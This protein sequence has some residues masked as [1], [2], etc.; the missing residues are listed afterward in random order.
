MPIYDAIVIGGGPAGC[1]TTITLQQQG[2]KVALL[3]AKKYPHHKVCGEFL[4]PECTYLL[5]QLGVTETLCAANPKVIDTVC[6]TAADDT[7]WEA[8]L[9]GQALGI[10]RYMLDAIM[11]AHAAQSGAELH[12]STT[13]TAIAGNIRDGFEVR[14]RNSK[15]EHSFSG[16]LVI[17]AH[18]KRSNLDRALRRRFLQK[19]QPYIGL[20]AHF[21]GPPLP[22]RI[23][24]HTFRG[25]YCG[26]S[27]IEDG[28]IN[29]CLLAQKSALHSSENQ[30]D[31]ASFIRWM[32]NQNPHLGHWLSDASIV[33][34][35]WLS[36]SEVPFIA[37]RPVVNEVLMVGDASGLI[38]PLAGDGIALAL[39]SGLIAG[40][41]ASKFLCGEISGDRLPDE[42]AS[43]WRN[44]FQS[45]LRL[46]WML[47][48]LMFTPALSSSV[49]K[50]IRTAPPLGDY[51]IR[52][53]RDM[54]LV[55]NE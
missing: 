3:E 2:W 13:A 6:I 54:R 11:A 36:I 42:Y 19:S 44:E 16:R 47:Q 29:L 51:L 27:E 12:E 18:G 8:H 35:R 39:H 10:S 33:S 40:N 1:S 14:A 53:T 17:G 15:G 5:D 23:E 37:K 28:S 41:F 25:G 38:A 31:I 55:W 50:I 49:L 45:R 34:E 4:S 26:M 9:P 21:N 43:I 7:R 24:L 32:S 46:S 20:K 22:G 48:P 52:K 30:T